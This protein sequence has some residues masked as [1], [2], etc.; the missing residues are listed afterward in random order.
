MEC[1]RCGEEQQETAV[2]ALV[3]VL[4]NERIVCRECEE[5]DAETDLIDMA[6]TM[7]GDR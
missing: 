4:P 1:S 2:E 7:W 3:E 6:E 5:A